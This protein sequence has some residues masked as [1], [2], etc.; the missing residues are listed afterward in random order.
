M[1]CSMYTRGGRAAWR[2]GVIVVASPVHPCHNDALAIFDGAS[3]MDKTRLTEA[4]VK[5]MREGLAEGQSRR[6]YAELLGVGQE[7][8]ARIAR[9]DTWK[10][11][12]AG[13]R[14]GEGERNGR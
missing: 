10:S 12:A 5:A 2:H 4:Q 6:Y 13:W 14:G 3:R 11:Q 9:G 1:G 7:T 8:V